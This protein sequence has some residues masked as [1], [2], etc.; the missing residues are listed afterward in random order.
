MHQ[1][2]AYVANSAT[3]SIKKINLG[4]VNTPFRYLFAAC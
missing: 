4:G 2:S 3:K 1:T